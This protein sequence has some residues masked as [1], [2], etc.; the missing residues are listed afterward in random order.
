MKYP[1]SIFLAL[2]SSVTF[3]LSA[4]V[5]P[6]VIPDAG[7]PILEV[8]S[9]FDLEESPKGIS[10]RKTLVLKNVGDSKMRITDFRLKPD[11]GIFLVGISSLPLNID[12]ND[13]Q[14]ITVTFKP[15]IEIPYTT[16][17][18]LEFNYD[19]E[20]DPIQLTGLGIANLVCL[21]CE[22]P[23]EAECRL[24]GEATVYFE[25]TTSTD[26]EN[27]NGVCSYLMLEEICEHGLCDED[28]KQCPLP[29]GWDA[30]Q[31]AFD[32]G[33]I[34]L[35]SDDD[36]IPDDEDATPNHNNNDL[37]FLIDFIEQSGLTVAPLDLGGQVW[38]MGRLT[39]FNCDSYDLSGPIPASV[40]NITEIRLFVLT[41]NP[42]TGVLPLVLSTLENL[43]NLN[44]QSHQLTGNIPPELGSLED[45]GSLVL[46]GNQL[47]GNIPSE[48]GN[49]QSLGTLT[50]RG[51][52]LTGNIPPELGSLDNLQHL[53]LEGNQLTGNIPPELEKP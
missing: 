41:N 49:L 5:P 34:D 40:Q 36:G 1:I 25:P 14:E 42:I 16:E 47:T 29:E 26:C 24:E 31:P 27:E 17:L 51:N 13:Q 8:E 37:Q 35:D 2:T 18:S 52:Q 46:A 19:D 6:P 33:M 9:P 32:A 20:P 50:I 7:P 43:T 48:L 4:C 44:I 10:I 39:T 11:N 38:S 12:R 53:N 22:P 3:C 23:P 30:G 45:L 21:S 28:T 15:T